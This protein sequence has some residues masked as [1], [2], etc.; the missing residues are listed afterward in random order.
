MACHDVLT[1]LRLQAL[2]C[3]SL[4]PT[5]RPLWED[6]FQE[7]RMRLARIGAEV[8]RD[9]QHMLNYRMRIT[10][11]AC[12]PGLRGSGAD[13][14]ELGLTLDEHLPA[15]GIRAFCISRF[16]D[17][18]RPAGEL[19]VAALRSTAAWAS[20]Q[21]TLGATELGVH[22]S[23]EHEDALVIEPLEFAGRPQ[24]IAVFAWGAQDPVHYEQL[25]EVLGAALHADALSRRPTAGG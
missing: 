1:T 22:P 17:S 23:L 25:R 9:R 16:A 18:M 8:E 3:A 2:A 19:V 14:R 11:R 13:P 4:E 15:I 10:I 5:I 6:L 7:S 21:K 24:G 20:S 12:L